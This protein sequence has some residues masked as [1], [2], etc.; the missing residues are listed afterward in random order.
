MANGLM[1]TLG[2]PEALARECPDGKVGK[3]E[4]VAGTVVYLASRAAAHVNGAVVVI[5]GGKVLARSQL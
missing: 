4:D 3:A 1:E 5:D 2:G